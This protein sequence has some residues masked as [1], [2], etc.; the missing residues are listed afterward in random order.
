[1]PVS[2]QLSKSSQSH[3]NNLQKANKDVMDKMKYG[4]VPINNI[5]TEIIQKAEHFQF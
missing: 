5:L 1:M 3:S 2:F 4:T